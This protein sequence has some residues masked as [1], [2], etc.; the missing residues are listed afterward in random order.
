ME[1]LVRFLGKPEILINGGPVQLEQKKAQAMLLYMLF[2]GTCTREELS[3]LLWGGYP[4]ESARRIFCLPGL[5]SLRR[6]I[7][8]VSSSCVFAIG[9][10]LMKNG[11]ILE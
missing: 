8:A 2:N 11:I 5:T 4:E 6:K 1:V 7:S 9:S 3:G 10:L